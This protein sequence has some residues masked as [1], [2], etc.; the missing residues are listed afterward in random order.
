[1]T[2]QRR[3]ALG[4]T[5]AMWGCA[6]TAGTAAPAPDAATDAPAPAPAPDLPAVTVDAPSPVV[7]APPAV[8]DAG[9]ACA[10][11][12]ID[13]NA[14][15]TRAGGYRLTASAARHSGVGPCQTW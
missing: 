11:G 6:E 14:S 10:L 7:D 12:A 4:M 13:L 2:T 9:P 1:M 8:A 3:L 15:A 5:I